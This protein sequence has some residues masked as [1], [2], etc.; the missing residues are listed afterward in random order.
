M[1]DDFHEITPGSVTNGTISIRGGNGMRIEQ[2]PYVAEIL[3][4]RVPNRH[5]LIRLRYTILKDGPAQYPLLVAGFAPNWEEA[6][7]RVRLY[8]MRF[9][10]TDRR[11]SEPTHKE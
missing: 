10:E 5:E 4:E 8:L 9:A 3:P 7:E 1:P 11:E 2:K 6:R